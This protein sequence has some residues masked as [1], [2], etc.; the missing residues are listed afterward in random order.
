MVG[1]LVGFFLGGCWEGSDGF[2]WWLFDG[3]SMVVCDGSVGFV[4]ALL[5]FGG[6]L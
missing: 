6:G 1:L 2:W 4:M 5:G 3:V